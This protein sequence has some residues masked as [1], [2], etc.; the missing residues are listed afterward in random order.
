MRRGLRESLEYAL[1]VEPELLSEEQL[2][3]RFS[4]MVAKCILAANQ[5]RIGK[6]SE[7]EISTLIYGTEDIKPATLRRLI[8]RTQND[9]ESITIEATS[10]QTPDEQS[11][12]NVWLSL[13]TM[14]TS[15]VDAYFLRQ[16]YRAQERLSSTVS[17]ARDPYMLPIAVSAGLFLSFYLSTSQKHSRVLQSMD[18]AKRNLDA[19]NDC[20]DWM[21]MYIE[22]Q[23][24]IRRRYRASS[25]EPRVAE[26]SERLDDVINGHIDELS[27]QAQMIAASCAYI[28]S[29]VYSKSEQVIKWADVYKRASLAVNKNSPI[30]GRDSDRMY[31]SVFVAT[32]QYNR[33]IPILEGM[34][35]R[36][37]R[38][39]KATKRPVD[40]TFYSWLVD[41]F[42]WEG[43]YSDA[44][45]TI[46]GIRPSHLSA[47]ED[48][49]RFHI[50]IQ[51]SIAVSLYD[52]EKLPID[53]RVSRIAMIRNE[54]SDRR[55]GDSLL[56]LHALLATL[57]SSVL[58]ESVCRFTTTEV[59]EKLAV[60]HKIYQQ[61]RSCKRTS[62]FLRLAALFETVD[63]TERMTLRRTKEIDKLLDTLVTES[64][65]SAYEIVPYLELV[66]RLYRHHI[67]RIRPSLLSLGPAKGQPVQQK[68]RTKNLKK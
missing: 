52:R 30:Y 50:L 22:L 23:S 41:A 16:Q 39:A 27:P 14:Y 42:L 36:E 21:V 67:K 33:A 59:V 2:A 62:A 31:L 18:A 61:I 20:W 57:I 24:I 68:T 28:I 51:R 56:R 25:F 64:A 38:S 37:I 8:S 63:R 58:Q 35:A 65:F 13:I 10:R 47:A 5:I 46:D 6:K 29:Q 3:K 15:G 54:S 53:R 4:P 12:R 11:F 55:A 9:L 66:C 7:R 1:S 17:S 60:M 45:A 44:I 32:K 19:L 34:I 48:G 49:T 43:R 26:I 40:V